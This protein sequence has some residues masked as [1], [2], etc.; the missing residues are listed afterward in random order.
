[1][2]I[3]V[4]VVGI[5]I[6]FS[7]VG[8]KKG[9]IRAGITLLSSVGALIMSLVIYPLTNMILKMTPL[10]TNIY[11]GTLAKIN[12]IDFGQG[13]QSQGNAITQNITWLP[14]VITEQIKNNNNA[15]MYELLGVHSLIEYIATYVTNMIISLLAI[16]VTWIIIK[17]I[18]VGVLRSISGIIE[19]LP[20]I[21]T[22][23]RG[24][25][26]IF[27]LIKGLLTL[28][29][30]G[31]IIPAFVNISFFETLIASIQESVLT[32]WLYDNNLILI[33]FNTYFK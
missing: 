29:I 16:L 24:S 1:M 22:F 15:A 2:M 32:K 30:I 19:H 7:I 33:I 9:L 25:G 13:I 14:P 4:I 12:T 21:S 10:Y 31:L 18:F 11:T 23:N 20:V 5:L 26:F 27:G 3:D 28:S 6:I 17:F 8:Y